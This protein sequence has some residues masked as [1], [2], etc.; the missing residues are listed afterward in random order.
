MTNKD[1]RMPKVDKQFYADNVAYAQALDEIAPSQYEK[2]VDRLARACGGGRVLD[3]GC[4][5]GTAV[6]MLVSRGCDAYGCDVS[7]EFVRRAV[8][9]AGDRFSLAHDDG[10]LPYESG[11]FAA[12]G[13]INAL[14]HTEHPSIFLDELCRIVRPGGTLVLTTPNM[15]SLTWPR[16]RE[17]VDDPWRIRWMNLRLLARRALRAPSPGQEFLT[18]PSALGMAH[19]E[20]DLDAICLTNYFDVRGAL[21]TRGFRITSFSATQ[22]VHP[23][24]GGR[25]LDGLFAT[26]LGW[27]AGAVFVV[28]RKSMK[29][30]SGLAEH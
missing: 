30:E 8:E 14:E 19:Y 3:A 17:G 23:G 21:R 9:R 5:T 15:L 1:A 10:T 16:P 11:A 13:S 12:A 18:V 6:Q 7:P 4:G 27:I 2:Y 22:I 25:V 26:P 20:P 29:A 28:A 24:L